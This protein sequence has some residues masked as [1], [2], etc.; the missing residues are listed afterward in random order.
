M[1]GLVGG[2]LLV[3][4]WVSPPPA[5]HGSTRSGHNVSDVASPTSAFSNH[6]SVVLVLVRHRALVVDVQDRDGIKSRR[7]AARSTC[8]T[9][10]VGVKNCLHDCVFGRRQVVAQW[11]VAPPC[12]FVRLYTIKTADYML[13]KKVSHCQMIKNLYY[14]AL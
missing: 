13:A 10:I 1:N 12:T 9:R 14:I 6:H 8:F 5:T 4:A 7:N 3:E 2:P 11:E